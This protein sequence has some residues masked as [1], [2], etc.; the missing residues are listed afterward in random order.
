MLYNILP[1]LIVL[2]LYLNKYSYWIFKELDDDKGFIKC[3]KCFT[4]L[5]SIIMIP[6]LLLITGIDIESILMTLTN[7][8]LNPILFVIV[9]KI[10]NH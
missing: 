1:L 2:F 3:S 10:I 5:L 7:I 8:L 6:P 4:T 9:L